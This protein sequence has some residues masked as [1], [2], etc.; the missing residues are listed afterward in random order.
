[1]RR[2]GI[3]GRNGI[4]CRWQSA[5]LNKGYMERIENTICGAVPKAV[6]LGEGSISDKCTRNRA[7]MN[8]RI[9]GRDE[10]KCTATDLA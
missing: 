9:V 1:M 3:I 8:F 5:S 4:D 6:S 7:M 2:N 10:S